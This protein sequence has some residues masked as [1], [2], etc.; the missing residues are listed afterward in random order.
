MHPDIP[1]EERS[2]DRDRLMADLHCEAGAE[3][4]GGDRDIRRG[5]GSS[6]GPGSGRER[7]NSRWEEASYRREGVVGFGRGDVEK[8]SD[9]RRREGQLARKEVGHDDMSRLGGVI[10]ATEYD[11]P[12]PGDRIVTES[13]TQE[14]EGGVLFGDRCAVM[15]D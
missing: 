2:A 13:Y 8:A 1:V 6:R 12:R 10:E 15:T 14:P 3:V 9:G 7:R 11:Q 4:R 5:K